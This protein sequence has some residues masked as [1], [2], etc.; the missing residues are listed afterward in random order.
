MFLSQQQ[1]IPYVSAMDIEKN[2]F[3]WF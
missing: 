3:F 1:N 2:F